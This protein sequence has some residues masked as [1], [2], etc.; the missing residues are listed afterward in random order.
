MNEN[1]ISGKK[2]Y[3]GIGSRSTPENKQKIMVWL[4]SIFE[5]AG[6]HLNTGDAEG[7]DKAFKRG[8][9]DE[10]NFTEFKPID[11][12]PNI[13]FKIA[14]EFHPFYNLLKPYVKKLM[15]RNS[16]IILGVNCNKPVEFVV[17]WTPGGRWVGRTSQGM[18]IA[19]SYGI[20]ICNIFYPHQLK[21]LIIYIKEM[22]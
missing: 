8:V 20:D 6:Y 17:C 15:A 10:K 13:A 5:K 14:E 11:N 16:Q 18:R 9:K 4:A 19:E 21:K 1:N 2:T 7:A 22:V 12:I 3:A